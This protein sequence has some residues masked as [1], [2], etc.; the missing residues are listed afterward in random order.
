ME[1]Q[2]SRTREGVKPKGRREGTAGMMLVLPI[3]LRCPNSPQSLCREVQSAGAESPHSSGLGDGWAGGTRLEVSGSFAAPE[4][5]FPITNKTCLWTQC[6]D[7]VHLGLHHDLLSLP[8]RSSLTPLTALGSARTAP[9][10]RLVLSGLS[11]TLHGML[12][13]RK[14]WDTKE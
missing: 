2:I 12:I 3:R 11:A 6:L 14:I 10:L 7:L 9:P 4:L 8:W 5:S 13:L 1:L